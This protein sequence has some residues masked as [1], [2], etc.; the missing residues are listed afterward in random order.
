MN[1]LSTADTGTKTE[2]KLLWED[3]LFTILIFA[4]YP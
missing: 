2:E 3:I 4:S 1:E